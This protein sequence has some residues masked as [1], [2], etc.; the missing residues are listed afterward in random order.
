MM[1][2]PRLI[3]ELWYPSN[4][5]PRSEFDISLSEV[6][7]GLVDPRNVDSI[8]IIY[9]FSR[10][11]YSITQA[12]RFSSDSDWREVAFVPAWNRQRQEE[13]ESPQ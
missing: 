7:V 2:G 1:Q 3:A 13:K 12:S 9:D 5:L 11:G 6:E 8:R 4:G 10:D